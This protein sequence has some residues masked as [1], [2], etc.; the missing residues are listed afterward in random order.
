MKLNCPN[1]RY[2]NDEQTC[3]AIAA[4]WTRAGIQT[5]LQT[6][7]RATY[8]PRQDRGE[9]DVSMVGWATLPPM[10]GFSVLSSLLVAQKEGYG[11]S[12]SSTYTNPKIED[13]TRK[14]AQ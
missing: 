8:F 4:M 2:I 6:E 9:F 5:E 1:D 12:N 10:D 7:S 3:V 13:L 11:G 14:S